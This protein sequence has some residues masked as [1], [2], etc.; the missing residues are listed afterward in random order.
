MHI[1][2]YL[3]LLYLQ[4]YAGKHNLIKKGGMM[5]CSGMMKIILICN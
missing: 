1:P 4:G 5:A 3:I 2:A